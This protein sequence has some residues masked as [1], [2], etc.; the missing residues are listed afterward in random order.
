[1]II[2]GLILVL[3][4]PVLW[5]GLAAIVAVQTI[6]ARREA[7]VLEQAFGDSYREYRRQ[8]WF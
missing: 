6:R 8:T 5:V 3:Q 2:L 1:M 4:R 7:R